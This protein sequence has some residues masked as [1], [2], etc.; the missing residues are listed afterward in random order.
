[1]LFRPMARSDIGRVA[2]LRLALLGDLEATGEDLSSLRRAICSYLERR[3]GSGGHFTVVAERREGVVGVGS[4]EVFERLPHPGNLGGKE[5]YVLNV[6]VE[7]GARGRG[8]PPPSSGS[9]SG[10]P[11]ARA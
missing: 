3:L 5:G 2:E 9:S 8:W 1:M 10:W 4:L 6:L 7:P 11:S